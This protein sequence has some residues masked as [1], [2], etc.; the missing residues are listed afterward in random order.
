ME[1]VFTALYKPPNVWLLLLVLGIDMGKHTF[2]ALLSL[3]IVNI[4]VIITKNIHLKNFNWKLDILVCVLS[5]YVYIC[6]YLEFQLNV[7]NPVR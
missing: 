1:T 7:S 2:R 5:A 3:V 4:L 6:T